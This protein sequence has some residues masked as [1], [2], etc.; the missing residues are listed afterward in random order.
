MGN[1][2][3]PGAGL[4]LGGH[5]PRLEQGADTPACPQREKDTRVLPA[6]SGQKLWFLFGFKFLSSRGLSRR[7]NRGATSGTEQS[8]DGIGS[9][10]ERCQLEA[11]PGSR[12]LELQ[13]RQQK[14]HW[15]AGTG[16][17]PSCRPH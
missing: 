14:Q 11:T 9:W 12:G 4:G 16:T 1:A 2:L 8:G 3:R 10:E 15:E 13:S 6:T 5:G 17:G 7:R